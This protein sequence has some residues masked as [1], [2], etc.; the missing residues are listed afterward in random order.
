MG[1]VCVL[2]WQKNT[3]NQKKLQTG[4]TNIRLILDCNKGSKS[5]VPSSV[6][7][8]PPMLKKHWKGTTCPRVGCSWQSNIR[9]VGL[10]CILFEEDAQQAFRS[11]V[12]KYCKMQVNV[13]KLLPNLASCCQAV[14]CHQPFVDIFIFNISKRTS[15]TNFELVSST[16]RVT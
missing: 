9:N 5:A 11:Y 2:P 12:C 4:V 1:R 13:V 3:K 6:L 15:S 7:R 14:S 10:L 16:A 8:F